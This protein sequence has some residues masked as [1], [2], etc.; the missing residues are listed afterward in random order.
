MGPDL[1]CQLGDR[2]PQACMVIGDWSIWK[3][4]PIIMLNQAPGCQSRQYPFF[5]GTGTPCSWVGIKIRMGPLKFT[6]LQ[7]IWHNW[8]VGNTMEVPY[9]SQQNMV[10]YYMSD[11]DGSHSH[12][13]S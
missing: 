4:F 5:C 10:S 7:Q 8:H 13:T 12:S 9:Q 1:D 6:D 11:A 3:H 2:Q